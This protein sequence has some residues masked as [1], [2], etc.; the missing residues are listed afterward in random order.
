MFGSIKFSNKGSDMSST[1]SS[2]SFCP[3]SSFWDTLFIS[4]LVS[5][6][7]DNKLILRNKVYLLPVSLY[8]SS[9]DLKKISIHSFL[10]EIAIPSLPSALMNSTDAILFLF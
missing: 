3:P 4:I 2:M 10:N 9:V 5:L 7:K 6:N 1:C 8:S